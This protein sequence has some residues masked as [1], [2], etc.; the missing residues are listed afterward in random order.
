MYIPWYLALNRLLILIRMSARP[1]VLPLCSFHYRT[2][3]PLIR[4]IDELTPCHFDFYGNKLRLPITQM[5]FIN[6]L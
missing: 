6:D 1:S 3:S 4:L 2:N 5:D